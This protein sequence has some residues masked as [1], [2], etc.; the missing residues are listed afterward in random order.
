MKNKKI[1]TTINLWEISYTDNSLSLST[2]FNS[3]FIDD[4]NLVTHY[5]LL[6]NP[7]DFRY[8]YL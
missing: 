3:G 2:V 4:I 8:K 1:K 7:M 5:F 6:K